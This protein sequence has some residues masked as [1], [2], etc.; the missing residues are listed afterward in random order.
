ME[1]ALARVDGDDGVGWGTKKEREKSVAFQ[2]NGK[3]VAE[4][5]KCE[6]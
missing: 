1:A 6:W 5:S 2:K 4:T 3:K